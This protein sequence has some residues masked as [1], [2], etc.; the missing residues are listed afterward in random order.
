MV[1]ADRGLSSADV[2]EREARGQVN[3][4]PRTHTRTV[5]ADRPLQRVHAV[6]RA[7]RRDAGDHRRGRAVPGRAVRVRPDRE[8][9]RR[10]RAGA[11]REA[12]ARS[13][14]RA[15]RAEGACRPRRRGSI[16]V[17]VDRVVLDDVLEL[18]SGTQVVVDGDVLVSD[19]LEL[20]ES[21]L[22]GES[23]SV[24]KAAGR[25]G[26]V[27]LVR[28]GGLGSHGRDGGRRRRLCGRSSRWRR[29]RFT[30]TRSELRD[31]VDQIL[32]WVT[33]A[34]VPTAALL[35]VSQLR[36]H[37]SWRA[38]VSGAVAGTVA[39]V[40]EG[41]V[42]LMSI[43]FA[44]A[45]LRLAQT[46]RAGAGAAGRRGARAGRR[47]VHRQDRHAHRRQARGRRGRAAGRQTTGSSRRS[48]RIA[49]A[50]EHP[51]AT[52]AAIAR[53]ISRRR[54]AVGR[55]PPR[56]PSP[57]RG[58][59]APSSFGD[60]RLLVRRGR[61]RV[62]RRRRTT[63]SAPRRRRGG[64]GGAG[65]GPRARRRAAGGRPVA[66]LAAA[67]RPRGAAGHAPTGCGA[68]ARLL[69][70]AGRHGEGDLGRRP[71]DGGRD[72]RAARAGG[73]GPA[74]R[75]PRAARRRGGARATRSSARRCSVAS[76]RSRSAPW[77]T[78]CA[79]AATRS[80]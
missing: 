3:L 43:A 45:V 72:R 2:E 60:Q 14:D 46:E 75:R 51:N 40:P 65:P 39:M 67:R 33:W 64:G 29:R 20:D 42:L 18:S 38:A 53:A 52:M 69:P 47:A 9:R 48:R 31:G 22:T 7:P 74:D 63:A 61:R 73:R 44:V 13:A 78:R 26:D 70:R 71:A 68:D 8:R 4:V 35:F 21:L 41:L 16:E 59:G 34:I 19:G 25:P 76:R 1:D 6:Q 17:P 11:A 28:R 54:R 55:R 5:A 79:R 30:L 37:D 10:D 49:A 27:G 15:H 24:A 66:G 23:E 77:S 57:R 50:D 62:D 32:R 80:P 56:C 12:D 58:S 36:H